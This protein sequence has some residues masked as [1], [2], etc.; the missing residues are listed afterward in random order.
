M[1]SR[2]IFLFARNRDWGGVSFHFVYSSASCWD[3]TLLIYER[4]Q[5]NNVKFDIY[6]K[7]V[8][9]DTWVVVP[10]A[11]KSDRTSVSSCA[12]EKNR[13]SDVRDSN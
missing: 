5:V 9:P 11:G 4:S 12:K 7:Y 10:S 8:K 2:F 3:C 13:S 6:G 1:E